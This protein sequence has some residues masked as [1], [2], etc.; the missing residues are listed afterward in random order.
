VVP[1]KHILLAIDFFDQQTQVA[2]RAKDL[3]ERYAAKLSVIHV[4]DTL[5]IADP[6]NDVLV[7]FEID[8]SQEFIA[9]GRKK[10]T[11][12]AAT[13]AIPEERA[14]LETGSAK[15]EIIRV[16]EENAVDLIVVGSH[17]RHGLALLLGSTANGVLHYANCDVLAVRLKDQ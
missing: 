14:W 4:V 8:L 9:L 16:S 5:P 1:Y 12:L 3:A 2:E 13:L 11:E 6:A 7:P 17:G 15:Q 10:L